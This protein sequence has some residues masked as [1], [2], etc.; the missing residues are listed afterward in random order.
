M[1]RKKN[2]K[3]MTLAEVLVATVILGIILSITVPNFVK[4]MKDTDAILFTDQLKTIEN[5]IQMVSS[6][7]NE[8]YNHYPH[9]LLMNKAA[10]DNN[11][12]NG[13]LDKKEGIPYLTSVVDPE[14]DKYYYIIRLNGSSPATVEKGASPT[15]KEFIPVSLENA[16]GE[17]YGKSAVLKAYPIDM[18]R[19][20]MYSPTPINLSFPMQGKYPSNYTQNGYQTDAVMNTSNLKYVFVGCPNKTSKATCSVTNNSL[21]KK[22]RI[23]NDG[24]IEEPGYF[25]LVLSGNK[26]KIFYTGTDAVYKNR[27]VHTY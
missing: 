25:I 15:T 22:D 6:A 1:K 9:P 5:N 12:K 26:K 10:I 20:S 19:F 7:N 8:N 14:D 24:I 2:K 11:Y 16:L 13:T 23:P 17:E 18:Y 3:G 4:K 27:Y 21:D